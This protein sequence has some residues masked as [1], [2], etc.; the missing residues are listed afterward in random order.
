[1]V[2]RRVEPTGQVDHRAGA[3]HVGRALVGLVGGDVVDRGA[4][5]DVVDGAQLGDGLVGEAEIVCGQVA[6]QRLSPGRPSSAASRSNRASDSRRTSTHTSASSLRSRIRD[7]T[8][9]PINPVPPVTT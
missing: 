6:D 2:Q 5:H 3:L 8:R 9:R 7:T 4:V 1:M